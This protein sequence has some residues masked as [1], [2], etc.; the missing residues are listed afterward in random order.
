LEHTLLFGQRPIDVAQ[1]SE[2]E[3]RDHTGEGRVGERKVSRVGHHPLDILGLRPPPP[4][5]DHLRS[6]I[7]RHGANARVLAPDF[8]GQVSGPCPDVQHTP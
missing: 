1:V 4:D 5:G 6:E 3:P 7:G 2:Q 8:E